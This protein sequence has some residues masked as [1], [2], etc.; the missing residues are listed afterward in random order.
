MR[1]IAEFFKTCQKPLF[2]SDLKRGKKYVFVIICLAPCYRDTFHTSM[3]SATVW[4]NGQGFMKQQEER[5]KIKLFA[6]KVQKM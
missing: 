1:K 3:A 6:R 2:L 4:T 5:E